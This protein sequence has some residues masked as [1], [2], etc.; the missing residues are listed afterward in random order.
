MSS[1]R[2]GFSVWQSFSFALQK[3]NLTAH[4]ARGLRPVGF[5]EQQMVKLEAGV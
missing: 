3:D 2:A 1:A 5:L 4:Q